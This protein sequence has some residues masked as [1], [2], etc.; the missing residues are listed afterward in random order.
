[1]N[2]SHCVHKPKT[3]KKQILK[4]LVSWG[5]QVIQL[6]LF[7]LPVKKN[8]VM[9]YVH[10]R[11]GFTCNP[12]YIVRELLRRYGN[13]LEI[14][15]VTMH[16]E[17]CREVEALGI[18]VVRNNSFLQAKLYLRTRVF[19]TDD[20]FPS[21]ARHRKNQI[22]INTWHGAMNYKNIGYDTLEPMSSVAFRIYRL[23]NRQADH[24][25]AGSAF[26]KE[27]TAKSFRF[28]EDIFL[29]SGL[30]RNDI[31][32]G[33]SAAVRKKVCD[34]Y[35]IGTTK[36]LVI[37][38]PTFRKDRKDDAYGMDFS[39]VCNALSERFGGEWL[40]LFR[41]HNF[42]KGKQSH[43][44]SIDVSGYHDMQELLC[45]A[46]VLISD[47][48]SCLYD[49]CLTGRPS[50]VYATDL[51]NYMSNDR[52]FAYPFEKWPYPAAATNEALAQCIR[53]FDERDY[54]QR[55]HD[56]LQNVGAY[57]N[58]TASAQAADLVAKYCL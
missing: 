47:Y 14:F 55:V 39:L 2:A 23:A 7:W 1:M 35:H 31:L 32:L 6:F 19:L 18:P 43:S 15:W 46:D 52:S 20:N 26:F 29:P 27:N 34:F 45:A 50:F 36:R 56:H 44:G 4:L 28:D 22:W 10:D 9:V 49:F 11:T 16:P 33:D 30:P 58:G 24:F 57:D 38:A 21:W 37:F 40:V 12:K 54:A 17:T 8:R 48:S 53:S 51:E 13:Q 5:L 42:V 3:T 41:N 25:L